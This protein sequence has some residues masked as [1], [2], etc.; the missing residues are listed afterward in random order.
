MVHTTAATPEIAPSFAHSPPQKPIRF[1]DGTNERFYPVKPSFY[2]AAVTAGIT[3]YTLQTKP[4]A[5]VRPLCHPVFPGSRCSPQNMATP[6]SFKMQAGSISQSTKVL[7][8]V[9]CLLI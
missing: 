6:N 7:I 1:S 8:Y 9:A 2:L 3:H 4:Y 5:K